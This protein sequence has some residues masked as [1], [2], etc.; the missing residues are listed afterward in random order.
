MSVKITGILVFLVGTILIVD[1]RN[2]AYYEVVA[3]V[4]LLCGALLIS[5]RFKG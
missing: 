1:A 4:V 2:N 5:K 3:V